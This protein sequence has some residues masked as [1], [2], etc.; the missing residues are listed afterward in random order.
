MEYTFGRMG[1]NTL[2]HTKMI[3][4]MVMVLLFGQMVDN[5]RDIGIKVYNMVKANTFR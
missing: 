2:V 1:E 5:T 3:R 4:N